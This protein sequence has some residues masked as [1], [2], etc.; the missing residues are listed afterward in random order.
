[1]NTQHQHGQ[2][3][4]PVCLSSTTAH[5]IDYENSRLYRCNDCQ[6]VYVSPYVTH[7]QVTELYNAS[8][9]RASHELKTRLHKKMRRARSRAKRLKRYAKGNRFLDVGSNV[10]FMVEA[11]RE[12]GFL[13]HGIE[14]DPNY[15]KIS[16]ENFPRNTFTHGMI[17]DFPIPQDGF[18]VVY[19]SEVIEHVPNV[20]PFA[21]ALAR[22]VCAGGLLYITT[23]DITHWRTP[24]DIARW[25]AFCPPSHCVYFTPQSMQNMFAQYG[26]VL[27][28]KFIAFKPGMKMIFQRPQST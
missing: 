26:L 19:C 4:C 22:Q 27:K 15:V 2:K 1:M 8:I 28:K 24:R 6:S 20:R 10:G 21:E 17:E 12:N 18:D 7:G 5:Y 16:Q 3:N 9:E 23:P 25:D 14:V 13:A 11:A